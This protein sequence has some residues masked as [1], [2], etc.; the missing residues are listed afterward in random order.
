MSSWELMQEHT[1]HTPDE[2]NTLL[3][4]L[5]KTDLRTPIAL[6]VKPVI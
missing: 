5:E 2:F 4:L 1:E 3:G 6:V